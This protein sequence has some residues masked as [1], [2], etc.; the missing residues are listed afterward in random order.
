MVPTYA[1]LK[2]ITD[3]NNIKAVVGGNFNVECQVRAMASG[4]FKVASS[5]P[6]LVGS[7]KRTE[8]QI[9]NLL[10]S[11]LPGFEKLTTALQADYEVK[12]GSISTPSGLK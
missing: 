9:D 2:T 8:G 1:G 4:M 6:V 3:N 5:P 12:G 7:E 11:A 10:Q